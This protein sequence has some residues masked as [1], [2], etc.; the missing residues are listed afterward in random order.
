MGTPASALP[1]LT[2][3]CRSE[4]EV[5]VVATNPDRPRGR[6]RKTKPSPVKVAALE[7]GIPVTHKVSEILDYKPDLGIVVAFGQLIKKDLLLQ[8]PFCNIHFSLLPEL[9]GAAP[10]ERAIL[11]G[12]SHTGVTLMALEEALDAGPIFSSISTKIG[13]EETA[14]ELT[15]RLANL[16]A[17]LLLEA[18]LQGFPASKPQQG[19]PTWAPKL[20][21]QDRQLHWECS[22]FE[23]AKV[24]R[25][26]K[27]WTNFQSKRLIVH[28][29]SPSASL[30]VPL[31][32]GQLE[33]DRSS[34][35]IFVGA[36]N[37]S[38]LELME[39]QP[40][41]RRI[42]SAQEWFAGLRLSGQELLGS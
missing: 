5:V 21:S 2:A 19:E 16:G 25:V 38:A 32:P 28:R 40:E 20:G 12:D 11:A 36:G 30:P 1:A 39:V 24:V 41:G 7:E 14:S 22:S 4:V 26:G 10:V 35:A 18:V 29:A 37:G 17:E 34:G 42:M 15:M 27:A 13:P 3:L 23:L 6:G 31:A 33:T 9:R 8:L